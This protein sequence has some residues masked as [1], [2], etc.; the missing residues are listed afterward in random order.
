MKKLKRNERVAG[1]MY[2]LTTKP[3]YVFSYRYFCELFDV[4]KSSISGDISI[5]KELAEKIEIGTIETITG[6]GGGV[7]FVPKVQKE[8][9]KYF[10]EQ[11]CKDLSDPNRIISGGF[12]YMLDILYSPH[13]VKELGIIFASEFMD[14]GIDYVVT[15]ETKGIPI[16]LMTAEILNVPLVIIR[17]NIK[18]TEG[19]TV[20]INYISGS[21]KIIQ[22]MSL[23]RKAL[24]EMS[25]VL[26]IDDFMKGGGTVRGIYEM[27][28]EFN[29]EVAG[30]GVLISTMSPEKKLVNNY[31][32]LMILKDVD[33]ENRKID[34]ISNLE[35]LNHI[36]KN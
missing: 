27:M 23:S 1:I 6:S 19:S 11:L 30:T 31:T 24:R 2:I 36:K 35:Y 3:N 14:K 20:N 15:I 25:K 33:E 12:I 5:I 4:K 17:K 29:V 22:T 10:L 34:L 18:V 26:I 32:S 8:K 9:T 16:A 7:K 13:I 28:E 21:T